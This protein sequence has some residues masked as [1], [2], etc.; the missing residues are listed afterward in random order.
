MIMTAFLMSAVSVTAQS[1][2][3]LISEVN[4]LRA[5]NGLE[6]YTVDDSL[7]VLAQEQSG[8][9]ASL[10]KTSHD[11]PDGSGIPCRSEN[12]CGGVGMTA[13]YCVRSYWTDTAHQ[14]TM[15]GFTS[16]VVGAGLAESEGNNYYTLMVNST[17]EESGV[18]SLYDPNDLSRPIDL[19]SQLVAPGQSMTSTPELDG[20][21]YHVVQT[22][23]TLYE[24]AINYGKTVADIQVLN[25]MELED[26]EVRIG[27]KLLIVY[28][29]TPVADTATPTITPLPPTN[30]PKPT[31]TRTMTLPPL[32]T[33]T[34]TITPTFTP[35]P[36]IRHIDFFDTPGAK[37][38]GLILTIVCSLG[39]GGTLYF[40]FFRKQ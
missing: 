21:V 6:P 25:G 14:Y 16:G 34:P 4:A 18:V 31:A 37:T 7:M 27:Q 2:S 29:G 30:T 1:A 3:D 19:D 5:E 20:S 13:N 38:F 28:G 39:L 10:G 32:P 36:L 40:G 11:R 9:Q 15:L 26:Y 35:Q 33:S 12:V 17:G 22:N 24:I 23:E 8:Y